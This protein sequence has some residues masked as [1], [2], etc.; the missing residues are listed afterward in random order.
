MTLDDLLKKVKEYNP[1]EVERVK[2]AYL[3]ANELHKG[4]YRQSGEPYIIH[5]LS[6]A[7]I[8]AEIHAVSDT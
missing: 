6:V 7:Y 5:P 4:Q 2:N 3:Y 1:S 8:L